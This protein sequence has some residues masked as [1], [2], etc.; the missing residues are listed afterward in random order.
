MRLFKQSI[1]YFS[2]RRLSIHLR[3]RK[4][5]ASYCSLEHDF[6]YDR[7]DEPPSPPDGEHD[8]ASTPTRPRPRVGGSHARHGRPTK[9]SDNPSGG[10]QSRP[11]CTQPCLLG[12]AQEILFDY[13]C[14]NLSKHYGIPGEC[15]HH[16]LNRETFLVLLREQLRLNRDDDCQTLGKHGARGALFNVT[17]TSHGYTFVGKGTVSALCKRFTS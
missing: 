11:Y 4:I 7:D 8:S 17:L 5:V 10:K 15:E 2:A 6:Y 1:W 16:L 9:G 14:P 12:L 3:W 13:R